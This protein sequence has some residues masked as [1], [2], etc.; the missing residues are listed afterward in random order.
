MR[1]LLFGLALVVL[2]GCGDGGQYDDRD[3]TEAALADDSEQPEGLTEEK[4]QW[5]VE[6]TKEA[7]SGNPDNSLQC[8]L[9]S[10]HIFHRD[11]IEQ[12]SRTLRRELMRKAELRLGAHENGDHHQENNIDEDRL[13]FW[14]F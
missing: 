9:M 10:V 3:I 1:V 2:V 12:G 7:N 5:L 4:L 11:V 13:A 8:H 14:G 6:C